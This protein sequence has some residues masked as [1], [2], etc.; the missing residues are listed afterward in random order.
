MYTYMF[1]TPTK[2]RENLLHQQFITFDWIN[3]ALIGVLSMALIGVL[4]VN[5]ILLF[6]YKSQF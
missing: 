1:Q 6:L 2:I 4:N 5:V 3:V